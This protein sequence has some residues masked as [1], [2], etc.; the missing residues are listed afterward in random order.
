MLIEEKSIDSLIEYAFN[1]RIHSEQQVDRIANSILEFGFTQPIVIDENNVV[2]VG[3]GRL[4]AAKKLSLTKVP[5]VKLTDLSETQKRAYRILDN[6]LQNDSEWNFDNLKIEMDL[7]AQADYP[8]E[9]WGLDALQLLYPEESGLESG[10]VDD[11]YTAKIQAPIYKPTGECPT[12]GE[13]FDVTKY[14]QLVEIIE[15]TKELTEEHKDFLIHAAKR[16][17]VFDYEK[18]A[19]F[20]AHAPK[21]VQVM[22]EESALVIVDFNKAIEDGFVVLAQEIAEAYKGDDIE[23]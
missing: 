21:E 6:K 1:N 13:L 3:H 16:H 17:I 14:K 18:I 5:V 4:A 7:L 11:K 12:V 9:D 23:S 8:I 22:M 15:K 20:Y 19:E 10:G 2:L